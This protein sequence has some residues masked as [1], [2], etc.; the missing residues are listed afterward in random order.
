MAIEDSD[1][2]IFKQMRNKY[3]QGGSCAIL[4][5]CH[6]YGMSIDHFKQVMGFDRLDTFDVNGNPTHKLDL[7]YELG[8]EFKGQY[9]WVI[10]SG[11]IYCC[12]DPAMVFKNIL[13]ML[14]ADGCVCHT[15]NLIGF[16][17]RGFYSLSPALFRDFYKTNGF[18]IEYI[19]VKQRSGFWKGINSNDT[20]LNSMN[21]DFSPVST[22]F[23]PHVPNDSM[24]CCCAK[25]VKLL[26][27]FVKPIP[28]HFIDTE[29]K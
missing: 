2:N 13:H 11:T 27:N 29:G 28:Q 6:F 18:Y 25:R 12:F 5:D 21:L 8:E 17:G 26:E 10:D 4:G 19:G 20:Y 14:K 23:V 24:I 1:F 22:T 9:D 16:F 7:N 15:G 3:P